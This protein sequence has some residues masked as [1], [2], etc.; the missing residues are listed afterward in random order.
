MHVQQ[1]T[2]PR[3]VD[4]RLRERYVGWGW[5]GLSGSAYANTHTHTLFSSFAS[6]TSSSNKLDYLP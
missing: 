3:K 4:R 2:S 6:N 1:H 5:N